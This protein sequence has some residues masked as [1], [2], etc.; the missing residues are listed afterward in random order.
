MADRNESTS[1]RARAWITFGLAVVGASLGAIS[2]YETRKSSSTLEKIEIT[3]ILDQ[4]WD[5]MGGKPGT[6]YITYGVAED[7]TQWV[8]AHRLIEEALVRD[9]RSARAHSIM[10]CYYILDDEPDQ[11]IS[12]LRR[13]TELD[14]GYAFAHNNLGLALEA[15]GEEETAIAEYRRATELDPEYVIALANLGNA[16]SQ[17]G[18]VVDGID[19]LERASE[20]DPHYE[21]AQVNLGYALMAAGRNDEAN[22]ILRAWGRPIVV[23]PDREPLVVGSAGPGD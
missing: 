6:D 21:S 19:Y 11:A 22:E 15:S 20:L 4:A 2:F 8:L 10:G 9:P 1:V 13:A 14:P 23:E 17:S 5:L 7:P 18:E 16:L 12:R 3:R